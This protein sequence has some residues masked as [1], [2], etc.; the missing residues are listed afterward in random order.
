METGLTTATWL[1]L[2]IPMPLVVIISVASW[3]R[4]ARKEGGR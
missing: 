1:W 3:L 2:F 4:H